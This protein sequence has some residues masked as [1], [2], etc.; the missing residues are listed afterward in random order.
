MVSMA[1]ITPIDS[2]DFNKLYFI[3]QQQYK[4]Y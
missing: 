3:P 2:M 4:Y 1:V